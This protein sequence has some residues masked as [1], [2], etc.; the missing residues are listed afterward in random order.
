MGVERS[1]WEGLKGKLGGRFLAGPLR[2]GLERWLLGDPWPCLEREVAACPGA[3]TAVDLG[4][5]SGYFALRVA[6]RLPQGRV[7]G[8]DLSSEMLRQAAAR[9]RR[10]GL[11]ER[12]TL[13][14]SSVTKTGLPSGAA[15]LV[16][17]NNVLHELSDPGGLWAEAH[18]LLR[19]GGRVLVSDFQTNALTRLAPPLRGAHGAGPYGAAQLREQATAAGFQEVAVRSVGR[20]AVVTGVKAAG[21]A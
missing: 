1:T 11:A 21:P 18:R 4:V 12:L 10:R 16:Y 6:A 2:R 14:R 8:V 20:W 17:S 19:P 5:G 7:L 13:T 15:D 3:V 9:A